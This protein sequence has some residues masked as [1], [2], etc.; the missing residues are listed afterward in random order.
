MFEIWSTTAVIFNIATS[1][2]HKNI[3]KSPVDDLQERNITVQ[4]K[5]FTCSGKPVEENKAATPNWS[6]K[7]SVTAATTIHAGSH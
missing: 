5:L 2:L 7:F 4:L 1:A 6:Q 3:N